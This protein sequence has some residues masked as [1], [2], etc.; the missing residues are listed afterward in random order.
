M[1]TQTNAAVSG[2]GRVLVAAVLWG[3]VGPAQALAS[4]AMA[5]AALGG[6][7]LLVG[8]LALG[9]LAVRPGMLQSF[10]RRTPLG[11]LLVCALSTAAYQAAFLSSVARTGAALATVIALGVAPAATGLGARWAAGERIGPAWLVST[12]AAIAGCVLLMAP[13]SE[14]VDVPGLLLA[15]VAGSCYGLYVVFAKRLTATAPASDLP[16]FSAL[17]L[18]VGSLPLLPWMVTN[19]PP[20]RDGGTLAL[21][22][23]LGLATTA[24]AYRLFTDGLARV[25]ATT[26]GTLSLAEPL[27]A[28]L[29]GVLVLHEHLTSAEWAG[30]GLVLAG[31]IA[32]CRPSAPRSRPAVRATGHPPVRRITYTES[33]EHIAV[34]EGNT[35]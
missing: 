34:T 18:L 10:T 19:G 33:S 35:E 23:W 14:G 1:E 22:A 15:V 12:G 26:A 8:G 21:I 3:T 2:A 7:R 20:L 25:R 17:T 29:L 28:A 6:W 4:S 9:L 16:A 11:P 5:P 24:A 32:A 13:G 27:A 30:C 31:M